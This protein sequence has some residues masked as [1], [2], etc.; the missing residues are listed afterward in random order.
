MFAILNTSNCFRHKLLV[1]QFADNA[2][3]SCYF[4]FTGD[5]NLMKFGSIIFRLTEGTKSH[6]SQTPM[7]FIIL[8]V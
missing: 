5:H 4:P 6:T 2:I 7:A 8:T 1:A 3:H